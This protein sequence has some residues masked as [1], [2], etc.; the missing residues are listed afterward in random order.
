MTP[1]ERLRKYADL[2][3]QV[4]ANVQQ[5]QE[6]MILAQ[7]EQI[8]VV[9]EIARSA[10][11][12]GAKRVVPIY[13]DRHVR[14]AAI[15]FGPEEML[16]VSPEWSLEMARSWDVSRP[17]I[18]SLSGCARAGGLRWAR[19]SARRQVRPRRHEEDLSPAHH[20]PQGELGHRRRSERRLGADGVRRAGRRAALAGS[21]D[22]DAP[23]HSRPGGGLARAVREAEGTRGAAERAAASMRF[24]TTAPAPTSRSASSRVGSGC[25]R[26]SRP[27]TGSSTCPTSPPR[28]SSRLPTS[29][30]PR[31]PCARR[32]RWSRAPARR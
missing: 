14:R 11:R 19:L 32:I 6:V 25:V 13:S 10:Y 4:G 5:G 18:I 17:A 16:G 24:A 28:R 15:E 21:R 2:T 31:A 26:T 23:R 29:G 7:V 12:A 3:V 20:R 8:E 27:R 22:G 1:A 30:G 9:R